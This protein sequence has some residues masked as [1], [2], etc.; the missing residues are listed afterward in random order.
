M[1]APLE[2]IPLCF[3]SLQDVTSV[4]ESLDVSK[5]CGPDCIPPLELK[6]CSSVLAAPEKNS[7]TDALYVVFDKVSHPHLL[8]KLQAHGV[9]GPLLEWFGSYLQNRR[10][11]VRFAGA[12]SRE[13]V[14]T[15]E[16]K[17]DEK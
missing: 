13:F 17:H 5:G 10:L 12:F 15:S 4:L 8:K 6:H 7:S 14:A 9:Y 1:A 2:Y 3:F 11:R 16:K